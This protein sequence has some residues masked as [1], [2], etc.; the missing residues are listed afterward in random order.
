MATPL[1]D[2]AQVRAHHELL[3]HAAFG[4]T[5]IRVIGADRVRVGFFNSETALLD[6]AKYWHGKS[7]IYISVNPRAAELM[8]RAPNRLVEGRAGGKSNDVTRITTVLLD[9]DVVSK[10]RRDA[11]ARSWDG[12]AASTNEE[13]QNAIKAARLIRAEEGFKNATLLRSGN[14]AHLVLPV[15]LEAIPEME[16]R[17]AA[18]ENQIRQKYTREMADLGVK[19][20]NTSDRARIATLAGTMKIKGRSSRRRPHRLATIIEG[21]AERVVQQGVCERIRSLDPV[22]CPAEGL[23]R[24][25][26][27]FSVAR[28]LK[29]LPGLCSAW[30]QIYL[31]VDASPRGQRHRVVFFLVAEMARLEFARETILETIH[32]RD[33]TLGG[34]FWSRGSFVGDIT[35]MI[36]KAQGLGPDLLCNVARYFLGTR[37]YCRNCPEHP[38][39]RVR[40]ATQC[41]WREHD[42]PD[43]RSEPAGLRDLPEREALSRELAAEVVGVAVNSFTAAAAEG[44]ARGRVLVVGGPPGLGKSTTVARTLAHHRLRN[45]GTAFR[46]NLM[47]DRTSRIGEMLRTLEQLPGGRQVLQ[48][49]AAIRGKTS[50]SGIHGERGIPPLCR[51]AERVDYL[52]DLYYSDREY[53][54]NCTECSG[55]DGCPYFRQLDPDKSWIM[56]AEHL[57]TA[58]GGRS[59]NPSLTICDEGIIRFLL[60]PGQ[61]INA[62]DLRE[63]DGAIHLV[64]Y[65]NP[66]LSDLLTSIVEIIDESTD[67]EPRTFRL[68]LSERV[69]GLAD[70]CRGLIDDRSLAEALLRMEAE[71]DVHI[72]PKRFL[73]RLLRVVEEEERCDAINS[74]LNVEKSGRRSTLVIR[75]PRLPNVGQTPLL[76]LDSTHDQAL[77][78]RILGREVEVVP[79]RVE[80]TA[81][82]V[83]VV[84][85]AYPLASVKHS[86]VRK[87]LVNAVKAIIDSKPEGRFAIITHRVFEEEL[88]QHLS[89]P[90]ILT[91]HYF[92]LRGTNEMARCTD[93]ILVGTPCMNLSQIEGTAAALHWEDEALDYTRLT[94]WDP[95]GLFKNG[96]ELFVQVKH[97]ADSRLDQLL[98]QAREA[99]LAQAAFRLRPLDAPETKTIWALTNVPI[100][101]LPPTE[102]YESLLDLECAFGQARDPTAIEVVT[103]AIRQDD[104]NGIIRTVGDLASDLGVG[105][106][107]VERARAKLRRGSE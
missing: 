88:R 74:R 89:H 65:E 56:C 2:E 97:Y 73:D 68:L 80:V 63:L 40:R 105:R 92:N 12:Q 39:K 86:S 24:G 16:A 57:F 22:R 77:Y 31:N 28:D 49:T 69:E 70:L 34:K 6:T 95:I 26:F 11:A 107:T 20:D 99:E 52:R 4:I 61:A 23:Y 62:D 91:N 21:P 102:V 101:F 103:E 8:C 100:P 83:Q 9:I 35:N 48:D 47:V 51:R 104:L 38:E 72:L 19:L 5:E 50:R 59:N 3:G 79:P 13:L 54:L 96:A 78:S 41:E 85:A 37:D 30:N 90:D 60:A 82:V 55:R 94:Q 29:S 27:R 46:V 81:S 64:G 58:G 1:F 44:I 17:V 67:G 75:Q 10:G 45:P 66:R 32:V 43:L 106:R 36:G 18:F 76:I 53:P 93:L 71:F 25:L 33:K 15:D 42:A 87:N 98:W 14:G 84:G 7:N